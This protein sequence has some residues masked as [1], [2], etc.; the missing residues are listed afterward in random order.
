MDIIFIFKKDRYKHKQLRQREIIEFIPLRPK[1]KKLHTSIIS[2][3]RAN[4]QFSNLKCIQM[5]HMPTCIQKSPLTYN[6]Q[7]TQY[8]YI[9]SVCICYSKPSHVQHSDKHINIQ[10][11]NTLYWDKFDSL[12]RI[13]NMLNPV[14]DSLCKQL[15][16]ALQGWERN[17]KKKWDCT[18]IRCSSSASFS[19]AEKLWLVE[20]ES[21]DMTVNQRT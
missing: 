8:T 13:F 5:N 18:F 10:S 11:S 7:Y 6:I 1:H 12:G 2:K 9:H 16:V 21:L 14:I 20:L 3:L 19:E 15:F 17:E 4:I